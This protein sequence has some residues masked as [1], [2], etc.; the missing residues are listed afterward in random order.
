[1]P[2]SL[3]LHHFI[4][5]KDRCFFYFK[6][7]HLLLGWIFVSERW[8]SCF[9]FVFHFLKLVVEINYATVHFKD[10]LADS[11]KFTSRQQFCGWDEVHRISVVYIGRLATWLLLW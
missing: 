7:G 8:Q 1:M 6:K 2:L 10:K 4:K 11:V 5:E 3:T 9:R